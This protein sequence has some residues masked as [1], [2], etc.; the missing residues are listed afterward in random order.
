MKIGILTLPFN[1]NYGGMLQAY[2]LKT[3]LENLGHEV[4]IINRKPNKVFFLRKCISTFKYRIKNL[5]FKLYDLEYV[6]QHMNS[7]KENY[8]SPFTIPYYTS[9]ELYKCKD[10]NFDLYIVGS[11]QVWR[12]TY[13]DSRMKDYFFDFLNDSPIK[14]ISY[15]ASFGCAKNEYSKED[16]E[17]CRPLLEQ[18]SAISVREKSGI[19]L[20][21][22]VFQLSNHNIRCVLDPTFLVNIEDYLKIISNDLEKKENYIFNYTLDKTKEKQEILNEISNQYQYSIQTMNLPIGKYN[23]GQIIEPVEKWLAGIYMSNFVFTDSF[24]GMVFSIIFQK[25]FIVYINKERGAD[26]FI[27]L[28]TQLGLEKHIINNIQEYQEIK[29]TISPD[30]KKINQQ[31][32]QLKQNSIKYLVEAINL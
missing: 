29:S 3:F 25:P 30:W 10:Y 11:D 28:L 9:S 6:N 24:H 2:A 4:W 23:K 12:R 22:N 1:N 17:I 8:L 5:D 18:F 7:F 15:A 19:N 27:S 31:L 14:R 32:N 16:I 21:E 20:I 26:R 13:I